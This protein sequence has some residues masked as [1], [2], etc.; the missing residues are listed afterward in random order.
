MKKKISVHSILIH[1]FFSFIFLLICTNLAAQQEK[2]SFLIKLQQHPQNDS[3]RVELLVDACVNG[4]FSADTIYLNWANEALQL[5]NKLNYRIGKIR[6]LNCLGN[7]YYQRAGNDKA[8]SYYIDA[9]KMAEADNNISSIIIG[10]SNL[11]NVYNRTNRSKEAVV[12]FKECDALLVKSNDTLSQKRAAI[13]TNLSTTFSTL[14][15]HDSSIYY[16]KI[17]LDIC[18]K[19]DIKFGIA[20]SLSNLG[21]EYY[22]IKDYSTSL[23]YLK[24]AEK[25]AKENNMDFLKGSIARYFGQSHIAIGNTVKGILYLNQALSIAKAANDSET[26]IDVYRQLYQAYA[27]IE[28]YEQAFQSSV[29]Y[30]TMK[31]SIYG[32]EKE[33][34]INELSTRYETEKKETLIQSLTQKQEITALQSQRK[35]VLIYGIAAAI[36]LLGF[37]SYTLFNRYKIKQQNNQLLEKIKHEQVLNQSILTSI[38]AQMNPHFIFNA[39]NTIQNYIYGNDKN[40]AVNYLGKFSELVRTVLNNSSRD[41]IALDEEIKFLQ[42]Y[43]EL[44]KMRFEDSIE[45]TFN[46]EAVEDLADEMMIPSMI[47][48]PYIE[49]AFKHGLLHKKTDKKLSISFINNETEKV[50]TCIID[51]NGVGRTKSAEYKTA[52]KMHH[53][54]FATSATQK[55]L[56]LLNEGRRNSIAVHIEDKISDNGNPLGTTVKVEIPYTLAFS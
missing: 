27:S 35:S 49:N 12:L 24:E 17:V 38:K 48:Q 9:L 47:I 37:L 36:V 26:L 18:T 50:I 51:D 33:K 31:D 2:D 43:V 34:T 14:K 52:G 13:L 16:I 28:K 3:I 41:S 4:T 39:L 21:S 53:R 30:F 56:E 44:E 10:K 55:R 20:I 40:K 42:L 6:A 32:I 7:Y 1:Q 22:N 5:S 15:Q 11:A 19:K 25:I 8:I 54:S 29:L 23:A 46:T 45:T